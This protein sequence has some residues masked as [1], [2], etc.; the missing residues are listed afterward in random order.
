MLRNSLTVLA[1]VICLGCAPIPS[2]EGE[3]TRTHA[4][5]VRTTFLASDLG[6]M[7]ALY[8]DILGYELVYSDEYQGTTF[9]RLFEIDRDADVDFAILKPPTED[10]GSIGILV[11]GD[12]LEPSIPLAAYAPE[13]GQAILFSTTGNLNAVY[14]RVRASDASIVTVVAPPFA[15][16]GGREMVIADA[17]GIRIYVFEPEAAFRSN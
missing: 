4:T 3:S 8:H 11:V 14:E 7:L 15:T 2:S 1:V 9:R 6:P 13:F 16:A 17:N 5:I 10:G 12:H